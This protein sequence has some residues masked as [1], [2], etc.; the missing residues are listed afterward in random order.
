MGSSNNQTLYFLLAEPLTP[1]YVSNFLGRIVVHK[2]RPT[3]DYTPAL[4][5][6]LQKIVPDLYEDP[7]T[8]KDIEKVIRRATKT[9]AKISITNLLEVFAKGYNDAGIEVTAPLFRRYRMTQIPTKFNQL[10]KNKE[11]ATQVAEFF[12][13]QGSREPLAFVTGLLT[14]CNM[15]IQK[16]ESHGGAVGAKAGLPQQAVMAAGGPPGLELQAAGA[17]AKDTTIAGRATAEG[18]MVLAVAYHEISADVRKGALRFLTRA[19]QKPKFEVFSLQGPI[20]GDLD[21]FFSHSTE[22]EKD[23]EKDDAKSEQTL[24]DDSGGNDSDAYDFEL[25]LE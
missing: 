24:V 25:C 12:K 11:Y 9:D 19:M 15:E 6:D 14:C 3:D 18:E 21:G 1:R 10:M 17:F 20:V 8:F 4:D 2:T 16:R 23:S 13:R 7:A 22:G 5:L